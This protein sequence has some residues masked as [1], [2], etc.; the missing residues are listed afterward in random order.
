MGG[1]RATQRQEG[2]GD[3]A[4]EGGGELS[5]ISTLNEKK[6]GIPVVAKT[7][8]PNSKNMALQK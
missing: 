4:I 1:G 7:S 3:E 6:N 8:T 2:D 5:P